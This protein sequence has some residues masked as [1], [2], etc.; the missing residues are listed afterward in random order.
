MK[1]LY[2]VLIS[3]KIS[4]RWA[5][6]VNAIYAANDDLSIDWSKDPDYI[7]V[8]DDCIVCDLCNKNLPENRETGEILILQVSWDVGK[9]WEDV[10]TRCE[11][12]LAGNP[13]D[14]ILERVQ[15]DD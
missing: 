5:G 15:E 4:S 7:S 3:N 11:E 10:G 6:R 2:R 1:R 8:D 12:C 14:R 13:Q 9:T